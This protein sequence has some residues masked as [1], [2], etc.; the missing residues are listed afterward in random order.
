MGSNLTIN[1]ILFFT[2]IFVLENGPSS[3]LRAQAISGFC[4]LPAR[5]YYKDSVLRWRSRQKSI[6]MK[7][8][9]YFFL[10]FY[11]QR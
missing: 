7:L 3:P 4:H 10:Q 8:L 11:S 2:E 6:C 1:N 5:E 9:N